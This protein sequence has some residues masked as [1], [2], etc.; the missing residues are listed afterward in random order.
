M[1]E[2][3]TMFGVEH[4]YIDGRKPYDIFPSKIEAE[5]FCQKTE[6]WNDKHIPLFIFQADFNSDLIYKEDNG[7]W[8]Y[9]DFSNTIIGNYSRIRELNHYPEH[10]ER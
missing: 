4:A 5:E 2:V 9:D 8:N 1:K 6:L 7:D 10:F 3:K